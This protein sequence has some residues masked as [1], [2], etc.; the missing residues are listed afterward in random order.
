MKGRNGVLRFAKTVMKRDNKDIEFTNE[1]QIGKNTEKVKS[2]RKKPADKKRKKK[3][4]LVVLIPIAILLIL[5]ISVALFINHKLGL[6]NYNGEGLNYTLNTNESFTEDEVIDF[7]EID[8]VTGNTYKDILK[9]WA[10]TTDAPK[11]CR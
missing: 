3:K 5:V 8:D 9:N 10:L 1:S 6:I 2:D 11:I 4:L 7:G